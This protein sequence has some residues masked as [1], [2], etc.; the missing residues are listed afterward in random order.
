[1]RVT[2]RTIPHGEHRYPTVGDYAGS[3]DTEKTIVVSDMPDRRMSFLI[4]TH[5]L[6][7]AFLC[8]ERG[9]SDEAITAFDVGVPDD[10]PYADDPGHDPASPYHQE[11]VFAECVERLIAAELGVNWQDYEAAIEA[12]G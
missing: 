2:I 7:E 10:S 6:I 4:A 3:F 9:I 1:M 12:L 11:H 5:E 8:E